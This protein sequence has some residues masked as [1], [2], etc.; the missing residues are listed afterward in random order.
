[1]QC[2]TLSYGENGGDTGHPFPFS[3]CHIEGRKPSHIQCGDFRERHCG[4]GIVASVPTEGASGGSRVDK[5]FW[6][7]AGGG[8]MGR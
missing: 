2:M 5:G 7:N 1:M 3:I 8:I 4:N 6:V